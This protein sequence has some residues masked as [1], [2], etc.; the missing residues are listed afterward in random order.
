[1]VDDPMIKNLRI[2]IFIISTALSTGGLVP[3]I[4][5]SGAFWTCKPHARMFWMTPELRPC[6]VVVSRFAGSH[7]L[8]LIT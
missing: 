6:K 3:Y 2:N 5:Q 8:T 7:L 1:M 4:T